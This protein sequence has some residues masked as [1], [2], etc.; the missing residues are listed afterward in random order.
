MLSV[1]NQP[2]EMLYFDVSEKRFK[3]MIANM[4]LDSFYLLRKHE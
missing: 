2:N 1:F 3:G 4:L